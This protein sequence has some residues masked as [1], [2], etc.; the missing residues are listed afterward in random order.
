MNAAD[1]RRLREGRPDR[2][3]PDQAVAQ[4]LSV[5]ARARRRRP[6]QLRQRDQLRQAERV[7]E[8]RSEDRPADL[9]RRPQARHRQVRRVLP[10]AVGRQGLAVRGLQP[11]HRHGL[12]PGQREPLRLAGR[13]GRRSTSPASGGPASTSPTSASRSTRTPSPTARS[14]PGTSTPAKRVWTHAVSG[15]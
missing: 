6:D 5:L 10:V 14:R 11:E 15:R 2:Q 7:R 1:G 12:H 9:Q 3:R 13:Q 8:H 4:R